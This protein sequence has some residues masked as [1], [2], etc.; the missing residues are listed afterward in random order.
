MIRVFR[1]GHCK[2]DPEIGDT[3]VCRY[4]K[5]PLSQL[6]GDLIPVVVAV[7]PF[8]QV[9]IGGLRAVTSRKKIVAQVLYPY[10][11]R[12]S[13]TQLLRFETAK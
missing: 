1:R 8:P 2:I 13:Y 12:I 9:A 5:P 6:F 10:G 7:A 3:D 4:D 11:T